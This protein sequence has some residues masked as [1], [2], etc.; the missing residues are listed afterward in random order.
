MGWEERGT[1]VAWIEAF[2]RAHRFSAIRV[3][4]DLD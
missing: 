4:A 2:C 1:W 3:A